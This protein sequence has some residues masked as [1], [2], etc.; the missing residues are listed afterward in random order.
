MTG[1]LSAHAAFRLFLPLILLI[2]AA[3]LVAVFSSGVPAVSEYLPAGAAA[4]TIV[5]AGISIFRTEAVFK[6]IPI[7][8]SAAVLTYYIGNSPIL[9]LLT[10]YTALR[11]I[12][13]LQDKRRFSSFSTGI[14]TTGAA[15]SGLLWLI[16]PMD[17]IE[18]LRL[19]LFLFTLWYPA[20][21]GLIHSIRHTNGFFHPPAARFFLVI[22]L[23]ATL[24]STAETSLALACAVNAAGALAAGLQKRHIRGNLRYI[25]EALNSHPERVLL[26]TFGLLTITGTLLL[27]L[28]WATHGIISPVDAFFTSTSAVC[29][30]GLIVRN[31]PADFTMAGQGIILMLIQLGG[32]GIMGITTLVIHALGRKVSLRQE[33]IVASF[34][35][36]G[37]RSLVEGLKNILVFT[38]VAEAVGAVLLLTGFLAAGDSLGTALWRAVFTAISAFCN[39]GFALQENSLIPYSNNPLVLHTVSILIILGG[40]A[41][42]TAVFIPRWIRRMPLPPAVRLPLTVSMLLLLL[43]TGAT[44]LFEWHGFLSDLPFTEKISNALF[45]SVTLRTAGFNSVPLENIST[46]AYLIQL[47]LM[48]IGG[49]PG[50]TAGGIKTTVLAVLV[51]TLYAERQNRPL[52]LTGSR[53]IPVAIVFRAL[54]ILLTAA[55]AL[56][57]SII[58]LEL[59][60]TTDTR[61]LVYEAVSALSTVGLSIGATGELNLIGKIIIS[62]IMFIGRIGP[63]TLIML[64]GQAGRQSKAYYPE[65]RIPLT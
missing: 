14:F 27:L 2:P 42:M 58:L 44:L 21:A 32:L 38:A 34:T 30:T 22:P 23:W 57:I 8:G 11:S 45:Q 3:A 18:F 35:D 33:R 26:S 29:V 53:R 25:L 16:F 6:S 13:S 52:I 43:G 31:T 4:I 46:P 39:A 12:L 48:F 63:L 59:T 51:M 47:L 61:K 56:F 60:Q 28:P 36:M 5:S 37:T 17:S 50:G 19:P 54:T 65:A 62:F 41:P 7:A 9:F 15:A 40:L 64:T 10:G 24:S 49:S 20:A 1:T 55:A